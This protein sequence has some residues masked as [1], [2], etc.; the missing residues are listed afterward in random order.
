MT[1]EQLEEGQIVLCI[2]EKIVGTTVFVKIENNGEGTITTSEIAPGRIRNLRAYVM[3]GKKIVCKVLSINGK[4]IHLSLRRVKQNEKKELLD[5]IEKEK[6]YTAILKAVTPDYEKIINKITESQTLIDFFGQVN[7]NPK[8]LE[9]Y[10]KKSGAEKILK[11]LE[12]KKE[13]PKE[14]K[15]VFKLSNKSSKGIIIIKEILQKAKEKS[16]A[17]ISYIRAGEYKITAIGNDFKKIKSE[18]NSILQKI[19]KTAKKQGCEFNLEKTK[20]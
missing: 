15:Q 11:I 2:V 6:N 17:D 19:E 9:K 8:I 12:T 7:E 14:I 5:K 16:H 1:Q 3:P 10:L 18:I 13:R 20:N 4:N